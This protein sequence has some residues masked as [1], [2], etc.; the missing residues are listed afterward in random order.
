MSSFELNEYF[1]NTTIYFKRDDR[2]KQG[3]L[4]L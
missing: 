1:S 4:K 2:Q 3:H